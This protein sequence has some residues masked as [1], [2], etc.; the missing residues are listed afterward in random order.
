MTETGLKE[1]AVGIW[2]WEHRPRGLAPGEFGI[3][4][5]YA[6]AVGQET[7]LIDPLMNGDD[8]PALPALDDV[9]HGRVRILI[10][11]PWH[12]RSAGTLWRRYRQ[13]KA[14]IYGHRDVAS[15][16]EDTSGFTPVTGGTAIGEVAYYH[17]LGRPP[18]A[19][20]PIEIAAHR[21]VVFGDAVVETDGDLR[22]WE[23]PLGSEKRQRWWDERY[24]PTIERLAGPQTENVLVTHGQPVLRDGA[25]AL[26]RALGR[27][28]WQR[29][30]PRKLAGFPLVRLSQ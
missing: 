8:D 5:S 19:E 1:I 2:Q 29:Q 7:L 15:R 14:H 21:A 20:Q 27:G 25:A 26:R 6:L 18:R 16:L 13:A 30:K 4:T 22:V 24:R 11:K 9:V 10:S 17:P 23:D 28:P 3:R 12:T